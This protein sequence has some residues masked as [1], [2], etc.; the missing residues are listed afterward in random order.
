MWTSKFDPKPLFLYSI[1]QLL[2]FGLLIIDFIADKLFGF[3]FQRGT[4]EEREKGENYEKSG[5]IVDILWKIETFKKL[6]T[7]DRYR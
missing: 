2:K 5:Q 6:A 1:L 3:T 7:L 4:R